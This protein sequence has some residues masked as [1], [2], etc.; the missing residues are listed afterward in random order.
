MV[1]WLDHP[2]LPAPRTQPPSGLVRAVLCPECA[3]AAVRIR[4]S[5]G[6]LTY[7]ECMCGHR[8]SDCRQI[9]RQLTFADL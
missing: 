9:V 1:D 3:G 4:S 8:W 5:D 6:R 7:L 2:G